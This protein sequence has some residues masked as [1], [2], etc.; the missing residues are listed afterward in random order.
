[1]T[2]YF[3]RPSDCGLINEDIRNMNESKKIRAHSVNPKARLL[4][5][6]TYVTASDLL[7]LRI[8]HQMQGKN[9]QNIR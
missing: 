8:S 7:L 2:T 6:A 4:E 5:P 3:G 9:K 1:M